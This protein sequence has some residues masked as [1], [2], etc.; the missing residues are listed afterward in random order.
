M[1]AATGSGMRVY[2]LTCG[3]LTMSMGSLLKG[4]AGKLRIPVPA[5][6]V[7]HPRG[8]LLFD[9]G[10]HP[11][12]ATDPEGR[13]RHLAPYFDV[14]FEPNEH[15]AAVDVD[16][17]R[18][19]LLV[20]SHLHFDHAGGNALVP[21]ADLVVQQREWDAAHDADL[22]AAN[23]Y[24]DHDFDC[25]HRLRLVDG[26][27]D[28]FGDGRVRCVPTFGHTPGH[29]SLHLRTDGGDLFLCGDACYLRRTLEDLHLPAIVHDADAM[30]A[31]LMKIRA[32]QAAGTRI[33]YGHD[34]DFWAS[35]PQAPTR[36]A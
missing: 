7:A 31:S 36:L 1:S 21:N 19:D 26:E 4:E 8:T 14:H 20:N 9:T 3:W 10:L 35:V 32:L 15:V 28:V 25:G 18:V 34:P 29:Q 24:L 2:A 12:T 17:A 13:M 30:R 16:A 22:V 11:D 5:Y 6:L 23:G 27:H 33:F